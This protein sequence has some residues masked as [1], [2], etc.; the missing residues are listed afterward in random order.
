[1]PEFGD[2]VSLIDCWLRYLYLMLI[3]LFLVFLF[4]LLCCLCFKFDVWLRCGLLPVLGLCLL[5]LRQLVG[6][7]LLVADLLTGCD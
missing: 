3:V 5:A 2:F 6:L 7:L 4:L 1:M